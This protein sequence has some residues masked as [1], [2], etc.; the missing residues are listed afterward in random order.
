MWER[1]KYKIHYCVSLAIYAPEIHARLTLNV[2]VAA[3]DI[4]DA[5]TQ[6][7]E[8]A[9]MVLHPSVYGQPS[10]QRH[11]NVQVINVQNLE[12]GHD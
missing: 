6:A 1:V 9:R 10:K 11:S 3:N 4:I 12:N 5:V 7:R 8:A 2:E